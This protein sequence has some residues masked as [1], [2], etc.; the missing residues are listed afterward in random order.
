MKKIKRGLLFIGLVVGVIIILLPPPDG[1]SYQGMKA[2]GI[3]TICLTL[4]V[5]TP[6]P[7]AATG[8]L[9]LVLLP[10]FGVVNEA[11]TLSFFGNSA[12]FFLMGVFIL[13]G[14][15]IRTG[16]SKRI[17]LLFL[18]GF[19]ASPRKVILG[20]T[21]TS[22]FF[23]LLMPCH[24]VAAMMFPVVLEIVRN[25]E[26]KPKKSPFGK[27]A[28]LAMAWGSVVGGTGT[29][30]GG[31]RA[32]L[33]VELLRESYDK[34]ISFILWAAA[35]IP[36]SVIVTFIVFGVITR[37][38]PSEIADVTPATRYLDNEIK[39]FGK[40]TPGELKVAAIAI[41]TI[42]LWI[43]GGHF[44]GLALISISA[45]ILVFVLRVAEWNEISDY[46]NWGVIVMYGGAIALG[47][48]LAETHA[49]EWLAQNFLP[50]ESVS[51]LLLI[52]L[53]S[54]LSKAI[55][56][57]ISNVAAVVVLIPLGFGFVQS[58]GIP[59]EVF[60]LVITVPAG[61][62]FCLPIG[63]PP[64]AIAYSSGYYSVSDTIRA[65]LVLNVISW[66]IFIIAV[67]FYWPLL[68]LTF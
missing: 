38:F 12:V 68:G 27:A 3:G 65:G 26:L 16:L 7:L 11:R 17:T 30:L 61:L 25:L 42:I 55:T 31:A 1:L 41:V 48:A 23:S 29:Y 58:T 20:I 14:A 57:L 43:L 39:R 15:I 2:L 6:I 51:P 49:V 32:P 44:I 8:L 52:I 63:T 24:A 67:K 13:S 66:L 47:K 45:A 37:Y 60:V 18:R 33:A 53:L 9:A 59:P 4:W 36:V 40:M 64:N 50:V 5:T 34:D 21:L 22:S 10:L 54:G 62:A 35:A 56:E 19:D 28:F 46:V